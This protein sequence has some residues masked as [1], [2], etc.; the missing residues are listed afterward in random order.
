[1]DTLTIS[2][3]LFLGLNLAGLGAS[4]HLEPAQGDVRTPLRRDGDLGRHLPLIVA[5]V[6]TLTALTLLAAPVVEPWLDHAAGP[7]RVAAHAALLLVVDDAWFYTVHRAS[8][9]VS[10]LRPWHALHHRA[11]APLPLEYLYVHPGELA[12]G[13]A[14]LPL[15]AAACVVLTGSVSAWAVLAAA[16]FRQLHEL[17][18]HSGLTASVSRWLPIVAPPEHHATHHRRGSV[19]NFAS[20]LLVWDTLLGTR[21]R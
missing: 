9:R 14:G 18:I 19:G 16:T 4:V 10:W 17:D 12:L 7:G 21:A 6:L 2:A 13:L 5:N 15:G 11:P 3:L 20:L 8:H 1:M